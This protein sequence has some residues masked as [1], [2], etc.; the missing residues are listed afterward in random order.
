MESHVPSDLF[1]CDSEE[2]AITL[3]QAGYGIAFLPGTL[4]SQTPPLVRI[5][6][7][8][9]EPLS[10]GMYYRTLSGNPVLKDFVRFARETLHFEN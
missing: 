10:F 4:M 1:F 7:D 3:A 2:A 5:P 9:L 6:I 8:G